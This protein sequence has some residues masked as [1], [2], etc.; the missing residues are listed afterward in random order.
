MQQKK[1]FAK[2]IIKL[3][4]SKK[5]FC[6]KYNKIIFIQSKNLFFILYIDDQCYLLSFR[7][8]Q[9]N[10]RLGCLHNLSIQITKMVLIMLLK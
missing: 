7:S 1:I 9:R 4:L 5:N 10:F 6:Q 8:A 3:F 2:N